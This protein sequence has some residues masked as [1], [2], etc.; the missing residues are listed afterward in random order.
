MVEILENMVVLTVIWGYIP[1]ILSVS[2][3]TVQILEVHCTSNDLFDSEWPS[4]LHRR[5]L[6]SEPLLRYTSLGVNFTSLYE[7]A[8]RVSE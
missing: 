2:W 6:L 1:H 7:P 8:I 4:K 3:C 5:A